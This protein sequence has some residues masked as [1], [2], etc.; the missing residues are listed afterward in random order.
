VLAKAFEDEKAR[1]EM[2]KV[3]MPQV[4]VLCTVLSSAFSGCIE[5]FQIFWRTYLSWAMVVK[6]FRRHG[7]V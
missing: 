4:N 6:A 1:A 7:V 2:W 5:H 3:S